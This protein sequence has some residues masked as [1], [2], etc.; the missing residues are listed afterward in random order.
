MKISPVTQTGQN[1]G[2]AEVGRTAN[3]LKMERARAIARGETPPEAQEQQR[4]EQNVRSIR[5]RTNHSTNRE[6]EVPE[7]IISESVEP[8]AAEVTQPLSPQF[9]ALARQKRALQLERA[10]LEKQRQR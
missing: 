9:A 2:Q 6:E 7:S 1:I 3:P 8:A 10:A 5:M 4:A